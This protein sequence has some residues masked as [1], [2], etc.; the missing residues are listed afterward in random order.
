MEKP[1]TVSMLLTL[2]TVREA[3]IFLDRLVNT[4]PGPNSTTV[5]IPIK[6]MAFTQST[7]CTVPVT[8]LIMLV[9]MINNIY[10]SSINYY[11]IYHILI[12]IIFS[13]FKHIYHTG[14]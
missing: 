2:A 9:L 12:V 4:T 14:E 7:H 3:S 10:I 5:S 11:I 6:V 13:I 1:S 8:C